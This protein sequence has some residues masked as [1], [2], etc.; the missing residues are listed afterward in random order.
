MKREEKTLDAI[1][2]MVCRYYSIEKE[3]VLGKKRDREIVMARQMFCWLARRYTRSTFKLMGEYINRNHA[4]VIHSVQKVEDLIDFDRT[5]RY[6][7]DTIV[8]MNPQLN[9]ITSLIYNINVVEHSDATLRH[10]HD[11]TAGF[12][13]VD[14]LRDVM[15]YEL[16][17]A[18]GLPTNS[19]CPEGHKVTCEWILTFGDKV[20]TLYDWKTYDRNFTKNYLST[21]M[22]GGES[23]SM[24]FKEE[25]TNLID[26]SYV[27]LGV[28]K[29]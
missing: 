17:S 20:F 18:L 10:M 21:W 22:I 14:T 5:L 11:I 6:D 2:T 3:L 4:T 27:S 25:L 24:D 19:Y 9:N 13:R 29:N 12:S 1:M 23:S 16:V 7:R 8:D 26:A 28:Y 15:Y